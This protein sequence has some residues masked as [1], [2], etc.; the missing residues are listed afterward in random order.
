MVTN[1]MAGFEKDELETFW[2]DHDF[3][4]G[5]TSINLRAQQ[6]PSLE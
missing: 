1:I 6:Q 5:G 2:L 3:K 4:K